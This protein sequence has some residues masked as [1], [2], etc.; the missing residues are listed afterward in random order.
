MMTRR[1]G[2][3]TGTRAEYGYLRPLLDTIQT[4]ENLTLQL[5]VTGMHLLE[6]YGDS[7]K[8]IEKDG[9]EIS[10]IVDM[11]SKAMSNEFELAISIGKG[12]IEFS[13]KFRDDKPDLIIVF[14]DR[15]EP[16]AAAIAAT[17]MNIPI[18]HIAGGDVGM[19]DIDHVMRHAITKI[20]HLHFTMSEQSKERVLRLGEEPWRVFNIGAL[21]LDTIL[22]AELPSREKLEEK[23]TMPKKPL[24]LL[25]YHPTSTEWKQSEEQVRLV[26]QS[27]ATVANELEMD[28]VVIFPNDYPGGIAIVEVIKGFLKKGSGIYVFENLPHLDYIAILEMSAVFVGNSSSGIIEAPSLGVPYV[29]IGTRQKGRERAGNVIDV[30]YDS[31]QIEDAIRKSIKDKRFL[32]A[33]KMKESPYG[34]G[35]ASKKIVDIISKIGLNTKLLQKNMTY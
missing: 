27:A 17:T 13:H 8:E 16:F 33:V 32:K 11:G 24:I 35:K 20:S 25:A 22:N 28:I 34:D 31:K 21:T 6:D 30:G 29:C 12:I 19:G 26:L 14:G 9:H 4:D 5:L 3:I 7:I 23:Y 10:H 18:A 1:V 2:V 15:I